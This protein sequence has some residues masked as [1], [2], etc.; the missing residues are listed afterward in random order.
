MTHPDNPD[1]LDLLGKASWPTAITTPRWTPTSKLTVALPRSAQ[2]QMQVAALMLLMKKHA[3]AEDSL[4]AAL[5]MQPDFPAAQLALAEVYVR[6]GWHELAL[7]IATNMQRNHPK[8]GGR[9]SARGRHSDGPE[10]A[11][12]GA[13]RPSST[14][15]PFSKT[16]E[17]T[18]KVA[19]ALRAAGKQ[20]EAGKRLAQWLQQH[21]DD[22]RMELYKA[23]TLLAD[24]QYKPAA[25]QFESILKPHP[26]NVSR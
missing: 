18:I 17:L 22:L 5:A 12:A 9:L 2:A 11:G 3:A 21:P 16:S 20:D 19:N 7:Q 10:Q 14:R 15:W 25:A 24:K 6:K 23:E 1:L 13:C 26:D 4:K 8:R